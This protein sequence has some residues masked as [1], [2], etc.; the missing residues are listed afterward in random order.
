MPIISFLVVL[1]STFS[2]PAMASS[3]IKVQMSDIVQLYRDTIIL[4]DSI[5]SVTSD[6]PSDLAIFGKILFEER[7][8]LLTNLR[9]ELVA[10]IPAINS[11]KGKRLNE[12]FNRLERSREFHDA[13][14]LAFLD[15][16]IIIKK[17]LEAAPDLKRRNAILKR[18]N[19][20]ETA[21]R[22][23]EQ[24]YRDEVSAALRSLNVRGMKQT[25]EAWAE[26][27]K[28]IKSNRTVEELLEAHAYVPTA[29]VG[30]T[31]GNRGD[32]RIFYGYK[33]GHKQIVLTFDDGPHELYTSEILDILQEYGEKAVFF[34]NGNKVGSFDESSNQFTELP[35]ASHTRRIIEEGHL[36]GN[37]TY[38][39]EDL[40][41]L[42]GTSLSF[43]VDQS[44]KIL[45][46]TTGE[47]IYLFRAPFGAVNN[48]VL[49]A[50][51]ERDMK[52]Y[53]WNI[54]S[55]DWNDP[56]PESVAHRVMEQVRN[57]ERGVILLH[58]IQRVTV[59]AL[60]IILEN[61][62]AEG[63]QLKLWDGES[64]LGN[65]GQS[66]QLAVN[67]REKDLYE[68][69][70]AVIIG[71]DK[72]EHW[73]KLKQARNDAV[74]MREKL[75]NDFGFEPDK[76]IS[77]LDEQA[78]KQRILEVLGDELPMK[79]GK[80]DR[81][82]VFYA[83]H[84]SQRTLAGNEQ[85][86]IIPVDADTIHLQSQAISMNVISEINNMIDAKHIMFVMDACYG[87]LALTRSGGW[88]GD[89][90]RYVSE[91]TRRKA[92]QIITAGGPDEEV[93]D[94]GPNGH[95]VFT[96]TLLNGLDGAADGD[97]DGFITFRELTS[98][99]APKVSKHS[100]QTPVS[101]NLVGNQGGEFV[102][103]LKKS[104]ALL[105]DLSGQRI[106]QEETIRA[107]KLLETR[108]DELEAAAEKI[109]RLEAKINEMKDARGETAAS[110]TRGET[111][112]NDRA[113][114]LHEYGLRLYRKGKLSEAYEMVQQASELNSGNAEIMN[115]LGFFLQEME[116]WER[117]LT[118][119]LRAIEI[120]PYRAVAYLNLGD[121]YKELGR[122]EEAFTAYEKYLEMV[123]KSRVRHRIQ[124][125]MEKANS[126][127]PG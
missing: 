101:G 47:N 124:E 96:G 14:K 35:E 66:H 115:N 25:R 78:T 58:D 94:Y 113:D 60:P 87:G 69:S 11:D 16:V 102:F 29:N 41:K 116:A 106:S 33:L 82:L 85:G 105:S 125:F 50:L 36:L 119:I 18:A 76:V 20:D 27:L 120:D 49:N 24:R 43:E 44:R 64:F 3:D 67:P 22:E 12:F 90:R 40:K 111:A 6:Q 71:I 37:H 70:W 48:R 62:S 23:I 77:L 108:S 114:E 56:I 89:P 34:E 51:S 99:V 83:G 121:S 81:V 52:A 4:G 42:N 72:Y 75:I 7:Q 8:E 10:D 73:S 9:H 28:H 86:Y 59:E 91:I 74:G 38:S 123:P 92:R 19:E 1:C 107:Q 26:Y 13:D 126:S 97:G 103:T 109:A 2:S 117:S 32:S 80:E 65:R 17:K 110:E 127:N 61:L 53:H 84:G 15:L 39:H 5:D 46:E 45:E 54:D 122:N 88:S 104:S 100:R 21:L 68:N 57:L 31:R 98:Y 93:A 79:V 112:A 118:H 30:E 55:L 63:Y 95:S